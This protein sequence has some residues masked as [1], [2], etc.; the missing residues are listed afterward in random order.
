[1]QRQRGMC[2]CEGVCISVV[3]RGFAGQSVPFDY[4]FVSAVHRGQQ[5]VIVARAWLKYAP[6]TTL[7]RVR[8]RDGSLW[9]RSMWQ[10]DWRSCPAQFDSMLCAVATQFISFSQ[11]RSVAPRVN[12]RNIWMCIGVH[13]VVFSLAARLPVFVFSLKVLVC[14]LHTV[15][16][17]SRTN[18]HTCNNNRCSCWGIGLPCRCTPPSVPKLMALR[19]P[20]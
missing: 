16:G 6:V 2:S 15:V 18:A 7:A 12:L 13:F 19:P 5:V 17:G 4:P 1:M 3:V 8:H 14:T 11:S 10:Y 20:S 9:W